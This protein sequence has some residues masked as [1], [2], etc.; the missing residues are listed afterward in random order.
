MSVTLIG[1]KAGMTNVYRDGKL[2]PVTVIH[3]E[4]N[5]VSQV[6]TMEVDGYCAAQ[7][8]MKFDRKAN[9]AKLGHFQKAGIEACKHSREVRFENNPS[10]SVGDQIGVDAFEGIGF[11]DVCATSKGHGFAGT[12]KRHNFNSQYETHGNSKSHRA[13]G[14]TGQCQ[15]PGRVFKG[16]KMA[17]QM[18]NVRVTVQNLEVVSIDTDLSCL[19]VKGAVPGPKNGL[20][21][22]RH[23]KKRRGA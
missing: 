18:G 5:H 16:K 14:S 19:L 7:L 22:V 12:I 13:P 17:G 4:P 1:T 10:F 20:V 15:D 2:V 8:S 6:K 11:V 21:V 23:A 9:K 3:I